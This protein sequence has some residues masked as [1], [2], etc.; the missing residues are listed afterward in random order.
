GNLVTPLQAHALDQPAVVRVARRVIQLVG[1]YGDL[2][3]GGLGAL[4]G[5]SG[6]LAIALREGGAQAVLRARRGTRVIVSPTS[7]SR[8]TSSRTTTG[9]RSQSRTRS[10]RGRS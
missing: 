7:S 10:S 3:R 2:A 1:T 9:A 4:V 8:T 5:S 6:R